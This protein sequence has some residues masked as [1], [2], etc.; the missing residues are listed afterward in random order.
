M[1]FL[2]L[3]VSVLAEDLPD[4][5][6]P[7]ATVVA[8]ADVSVTEPPKPAGLQSVIISKNRSAA[9]IDG[10]TIELGG[11]YGDVRLIEVSDTGVILQGARGKRILKLFPDVSMSKMKVKAGP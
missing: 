4:P 11:K 7:P 6:R 8:P 9:I 10:Q 2:L 3:S 1:S 5:T